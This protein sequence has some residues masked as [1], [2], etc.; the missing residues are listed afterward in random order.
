MGNITVP[1]TETLATSEFIKN[2]ILIKHPCLVIGMAGCGK[3]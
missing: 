2:F 1:T 3:T